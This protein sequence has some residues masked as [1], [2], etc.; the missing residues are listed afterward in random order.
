[1][2]IDLNQCYFILQDDIKLK[3]F[4]FRKIF[5]DVKFILNLLYNILNNV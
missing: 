3:R 4:E 2:S 5:L 1:M